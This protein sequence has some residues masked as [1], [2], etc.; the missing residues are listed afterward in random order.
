MANTK[1]ME[2][3]IHVVANASLFRTLIWD[4]PNPEPKPVP[5]DPLP[6]RPKPDEPAPELPP[7]DI[8][9]VPNSPDERPRG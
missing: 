7:P 3:N 9:P 4:R 1:I 5:S 2:T 8:F 6:H